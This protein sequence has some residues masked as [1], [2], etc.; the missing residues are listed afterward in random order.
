MISKH[1]WEQLKDSE[2]YGMY[3][4]LHKKFN[5]LDDRTSKMMQEGFELSQKIEMLS[6]RV[7]S[8][9]DLTNITSKLLAIEK[10]AD[11]TEAALKQHLRGEI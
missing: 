10:T 5:T 6:R 3:V 11:E 4:D 7:P 1:E 8:S 2:R 9:E